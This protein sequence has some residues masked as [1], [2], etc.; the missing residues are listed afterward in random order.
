M[1][2]PKQSSRGCPQHKHPSIWPAKIV[3]CIRR[4]QR[5]RA[6]TDTFESQQMNFEPEQTPW[7]LCR[8]ANIRTSFFVRGRRQGRQPL[9]ISLYFYVFL[10][11]Y[12]RSSCRPTSSPAHLPPERPVQRLLNSRGPWAT[13][14]HMVTIWSMRHYKYSRKLRSGQESWIG[15]EIEADWKI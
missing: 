6:T 10:L 12:R 1:Q 2:C 4:Y 11:S 3:D 15:V 5:Q 8:L 9:N 13:H 14:T 7:F